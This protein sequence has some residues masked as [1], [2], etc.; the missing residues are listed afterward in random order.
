MKTLVLTES[1]LNIYDQEMKNFIDKKLED[2]VNAEDGKGLSTNDYNNE[3][4][5]TVAQ[6]KLDIENLK[7]E[8]IEDIYDNIEDIYDTF[9]IFNK[10]IE[11][12][13]KDIINTTETVLENSYEGGLY[14]NE[15]YGKTE[16]NGTP[17]TDSQQEIKSVV[18]NTIKT[19]GGEVQPYKTSEITFI[20]P[21]ALNGVNDVYDVLTF[22]G[23]IR[24]FAKVVFDGSDDEIWG[25]YE[26]NNVGFLINLD[27]VNIIKTPPTT[28]DV[29]NILCSMAK[30]TSRDDLFNSD[31]NFAVAHNANITFYSS[32]FSNEEDWRTFLQ[33][34][35]MTV[36][37]E[38]ATPT[39]ELLPKADMIALNTLK[40]FD[41]T[42]Y[43]ETDSEVQ[44][45]IDVDY[46]CTEIGATALESANN[47]NINKVIASSLNSVNS[48]TY[49]LT[50]ENGKIVLVGS[51]GSV[52]S[53]DY[54]DA[55][56]QT[57]IQESQPSTTVNGS[58]WI[59]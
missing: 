22:E 1:G 44:P 54:S 40:T 3:E 53:V 33:A 35:P 11:D 51:D 42:T 19:Y 16:Q 32:Q 31:N 43:V 10:D 6:N 18:L 36:V 28:Q 49:E 55:I 24:R 34:N 17:S 21:I 30:V 45:I 48:I 29:P 27:L 37:Y 5:N 13:S 39:L 25:Y 20:D 50:K 46:G 26:S 41:G 7:N 58:I 15:I 59:E 56:T 9:E 14:I 23:I 57:Y 4:K 38:L 47:I 12:S 52:S 2:K 8:V